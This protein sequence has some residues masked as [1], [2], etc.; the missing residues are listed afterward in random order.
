M[1][2]TW[3]RLAAFWGGC[4]VA[5]S[6]L[7]FILIPTVWSLIFF[8]ACVLGIGAGVMYSGT[9][10]FYL[11]LDRHEKGVVAGSASF[12]FVVSKAFWTPIARRMVNPENYDIDSQ[13]LFPDSVASR[14]IHFLWLVVYVTLGLTVL[15]TALFYRSSYLY[16]LKRGRKSFRSL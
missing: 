7:C 9:L 5:L 11:T 10:Y 4:S 1:P 16:I 8:M 6:F 12:F 13:G 3:V 15:A 14:T 2:K